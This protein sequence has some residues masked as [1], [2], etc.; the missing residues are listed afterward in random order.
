MDVYFLIYTSKLNN[1]LIPDIKKT[2]PPVHRGKNINIKYVT[3]LVGSAPLF[4]FFTNYPQHVHESYKRFLENKIREH[5][6]FEGV[7]IR[8]I[9]KEK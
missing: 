1:I 5:F 8:I 3:Q 2:P 7:P 6:G 4:A 9:F